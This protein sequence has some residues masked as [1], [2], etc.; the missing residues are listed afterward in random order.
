MFIVNS[1]LFK[2]IYT[3]DDSDRSSRQRNFYLTVYLAPIVLIVVECIF[4]YWASTNNYLKKADTYY[5]YF[6]SLT[7]AIFLFAYNRKNWLKMPDGSYH[8]IKGIS[9]TVKLSLGEPAEYEVEYFY[10]WKD[11]ATTTFMGFVTIALSVWLGFNNPKSL[12]MPI[13]ANLTGLFLLYIGLK[14]LGDKTAKLKIAKTGLWTKKLGFVNWDDINF[15]E[16]VKDKSGKSPQLWL[17]IRLKGTKFEEANQPDERLLLS[18]L[19][20]KETVEM[21]INNSITNYNNLKKQSSS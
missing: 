10:S 9:P 1:N 20:D 12:L 6:M 7:P 5:G 2:M 19:K 15:A 14:G 16:V 17:E 21:S 13:I 18:E 4:I 3:N 11:K 8:N